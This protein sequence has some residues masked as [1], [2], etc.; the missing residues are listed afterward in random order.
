MADLYQSSISVA[1][2]SRQARIDAG[3]QAFV[4]VIKKLTGLENVDS[5][6]LVKQALRDY[7][8]YLKKYEYVDYPE[9]GVAARF[10]FEEQ[11]VN[12]LVRKANWPFWGNRRPQIVL[13][14]VIED[15]NNRDFI[16]RESYPQLERLIYD[17]A[18]EWGLPIL[19]PLLDLED[20]MQVGVTEVWG[21]FSAQVETASKRYGAERVITAR[22]FQQP[23]SSSWMLEWRQTDAQN[24]EA[25]QLV[26][27]QQV[28]ISQMV[29]SLA[30]SL[31]QEF[32]IENSAQATRTTS[33]LTVRK[34]VTFEQVERIKRR[35]QTISS[36]K[37]VDV[38]S[39][40]GDVVEFDIAHVNSISDLKKALSLEQTLRVYI[41]PSVFYH[42]DNETDLIY[43]W[44]DQ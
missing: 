42:V 14:M 1:D 21:N 39:R 9:G 20:R 18:A 40:K 2:K 12:E 15:N 5:H 43:E 4:H 27:D 22:V 31:L 29:E 38:F 26:G 36:I 10:L 8:F 34:L 32:S 37:D 41:D 16:T 7:S 3:Q 11:K 35:L 25:Q 23:A 6:P 17:K 44:V 13:W 28:I 30:K 19:V 33:R 24:F